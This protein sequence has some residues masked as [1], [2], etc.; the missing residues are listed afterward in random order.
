MELSRLIESSYQDN[1]HVYLSIRFL[2]SI[3]SAEDASSGPRHG[4]L[5]TKTKKKSFE[6]GLN[7]QTTHKLSR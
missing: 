6:N 4:P 1:S 7:S 5:S 3:L 2:S